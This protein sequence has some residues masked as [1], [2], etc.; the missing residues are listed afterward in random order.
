[1]LFFNFEKLSLDFRLVTRFVVNQLEFKF[2]TTYRRIVTLSFSRHLDI[3]SVVDQMMKVARLS[4]FNKQ[5]TIKCVWAVSNVKESE[6]LKEL[7]EDV[8]SLIC[9]LVKHKVNLI[10]TFNRVEI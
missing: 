9:D 8:M 6:A 1:M 2:R 3:K 4:S 10:L 5:I 7:S